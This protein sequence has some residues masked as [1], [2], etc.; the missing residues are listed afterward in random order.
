LHPLESAAFER[1]THKADISVNRTSAH[2][3]AI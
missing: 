2:N 1:R 3:Y